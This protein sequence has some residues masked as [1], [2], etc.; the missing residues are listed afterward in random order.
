MVNAVSSVLFSKQTSHN[1]IACFQIIIFLTDG[2]PTVGETDPREIQRNVIEINNNSSSINKNGKFPI[3][4]LAFGRDADYNLIRNISVSS[5]AY[6]RRIFEGSDAALQLE[7]F[8]LQLANPLLNDVTFK[9]IGDS[10]QVKFYRSRPG[11]SL[12]RGRES[13]TCADLIQLENWLM[14]Q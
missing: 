8:Y 14:C 3:Y 7:D 9:Y 5:D 1:F 13:T 10:K 2:A 12:C 11:K 6:A 4:G